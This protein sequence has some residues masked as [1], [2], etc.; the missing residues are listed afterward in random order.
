MRKKIKEEKRKEKQNAKTYS[1]VA[2]HNTT[3]NSLA[4]TNAPVEKDTASKIL[5]IILHCHMHNLAEPGSYNTEI[6]KL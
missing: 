2:A 1:Q 4:T 3:S 5:T 6:N